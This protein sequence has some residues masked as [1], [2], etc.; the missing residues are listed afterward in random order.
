[1]EMTK[2]TCTGRDVQL[3]Q[4]Y[5]NDVTPH[6]SNKVPIFGLAT[7]NTVL[8]LQSPLGMRRELPEGN[9]LG[10][11]GQHLC[12]FTLDLKPASDW[13]NYVVTQTAPF[14]NPV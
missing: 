13:A 10:H 9:A 7:T 3:L 12:N 14:Q 1:M 5:L 4:T 2:G 6:R 11:L 8:A